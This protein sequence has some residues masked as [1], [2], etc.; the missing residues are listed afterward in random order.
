[1]PINAINKIPKFPLKDKSSLVL[2]PTTNH[3]KY[4]FEVYNYLGILIGHIGRK[5]SNH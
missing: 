3:P 5:K 4:L 1:M 2:M